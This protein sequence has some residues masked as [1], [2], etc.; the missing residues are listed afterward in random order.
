MI[1]IFKDKGIWKIKN[2]NEKGKDELLYEFE[3]LRFN[4]T[5]NFELVETLVNTL[6]ENYPDFQ[7]YF[8]K[9]IRN[10]VNKKLDQKQILKHCD[11]FISYSK[12]YI[13]DS[14]INFSRFADSSKKSKTSILFN[15]EEVKNILICSTALK[16]YAIIAY[17]ANFRLPEK[18]HREAYA[19]LTNLCQTTDIINKIYQLIRSRYCGSAVSDTYIWEMLKMNISETPESYS[20]LVFNYLMSQLFPTL[21]PDSNP[22]AYIV[23]VVDESISWLVRTTVNK[24]IVY[25][26][27]FGD[28]SE[29]YGNIMNKNNLQIKCCN[30]TLA[31]ASTT[32][33][34]MMREDYS[35]NDEQMDDVSKRLDDILIIYPHMNRLSI[36]LISKVLDI[37]VDLLEKSPP[38]HIMLTSYLIYNCGKDSFNDVFPILSE[39]LLC[40]SKI[41][42]YQNDNS[43]Y[44]IK[45]P[46]YVINHNYTLFGFTSKKI[47][48]EVTSCICGVLNSCRKNLIYL[49]N[50]R[51][52]SKFNYNY[53]ENEVTTFYGGLYGNGLNELFDTMAIEADKYF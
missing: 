23:G 4:M 47:F 50:G 32:A 42:I 5:A 52:L 14:E 31:K 18:D 49:H 1:K 38:K 22:I 27:M 26:E 8:E 6:N 13:N 48:F 35:L 46:E 53:L 2:I 12:K 29:L 10:L 45:T 28:G 9:F 30:N 24:K 19:R 16:L 20:M 15:E 37:P 43:A 41:K 40:T 17:D 39:Y 44:T 36:P 21:K 3:H 51:D 33:L 11:K 7:V 34:D 25:S